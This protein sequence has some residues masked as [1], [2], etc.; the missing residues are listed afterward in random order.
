MTQFRTAI[1]IANR[2]LDHCGQ[3]PLGPQGFLEPSKKARL[4]ARLYDNIR[5]SELRRR[6][7]RFATK[8]ALLRAV[9]PDMMLI[10][11]SMWSPTTTYFI[12][13]VVTDIFGIMW[14]SNVPDNLNQEPGVA[15]AWDFY[16]GPVCV[17]NW[18]ATP[19]QAYFPGELVYIAPG[20][21]TY[22]VYKSLANTNTD[23]PA[24]ATTW[25]ATTL[26]QKNQIVIWPGL[27][28]VTVPPTPQPPQVLYI[29]LIN[30]NRGQQPDLTSAVPWNSGLTYTLGQAVR[31]SDGFIYTSQIN[32]NINH[33]PVADI[34]TNW[35]NTG[36]LA[37]WASDFNQATSG[38]GSDKWLQVNCQLT[39]FVT[40]Y[41]IGVGPSTQS[42]TKNAYL[43]P[44]NYLREAPQDPKAGS[45]SY[46][47]A[48][49][50]LAYGDWTYEN[51]MICSMQFD[52]ITY[53]FVA[54]YADVRGMDPMFIEGLA[55]RM[56]LEAVEPLTQS[57]DKTK[58]IAQKFEK[59]QGEAGIVNGIETGPVEP[60]VDDWLAA[61]G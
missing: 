23:N 27:V 22:K 32:G 46:L 9:T 37:A 39:P 2:A 1:D 44:A 30:L 19:K 28:P 43:F 15:L 26:Y 52:P 4:I 29:S 55:L 51:N 12:G 11:P 36:R 10:S 48:F 61:R 47:G 7:W 41:P 6:V 13:S 33:N 58:M 18:N 34:G 57:A 59:F 60:P 50:G 17:F 5:R 8:R 42:Q 16:F 25:D 24:T 38:T 54:D 3:D 40:T 20:D 53:R 45:T 49:W 21:G 35:L 56:A 31:G 14:T